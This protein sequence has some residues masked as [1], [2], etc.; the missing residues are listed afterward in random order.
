MVQHKGA[1]QNMLTRRIRTAFPV[2]ILFLLFFSTFDLVFGGQSAERGSFQLIITQSNYRKLTSQKAYTR[3][4]TTKVNFRKGPSVLYKVIT[5]LPWATEVTVNSTDKDPNGWSQV[6]YNG[7]SGFVKT[8]FLSDE[9]PE[10]SVELLSWSEAKALI[11]IGADISVYDVYTG[12]V[13]YVRSFS[14]GNHADVE[15]I[16]SQDTSIMKSTFGSWDWEGR[17]VWV[18]VNGHTMAAAINGM[19]HGGGIN[20]SNNMNG[21]VCLHFKGSTVHNGNRSYESRLQ[22]VVN[23]AWNAVE[24]MSFK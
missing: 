1:K 17:P 12:K 6:D 14:N 11:P 15:P 24:T 18:T 4:T 10:S 9:K 23:T 16:T 22:S 20:D 3:Y 13:Y 5:Q 8:E 2:L 19:P 7:E 21:Q